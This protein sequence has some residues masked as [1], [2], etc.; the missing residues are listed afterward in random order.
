MISYCGIDCEHC[1]AYVATRTCDNGLKARVAHQWSK[2]YGR[3][4]TPEEV[5]CGGCTC[6]GTHGIYCD[7]MC[8]VKPCCREKG[9]AHC[10][11]CAEFPCEKLKEIFAYYPG[12]ED[13]L[14]KESD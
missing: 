12:A 1:D 13:R 14:K 4:I 8:R 10:G 3:E 2:I 6:V 7:T 5:S 9:L 11:R